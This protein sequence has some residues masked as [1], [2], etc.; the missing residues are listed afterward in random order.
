MHIHGII[1][2][3]AT[4]MLEGGCGPGA[5]QAKAARDYL[6]KNKMNTA[7]VLDSD[8]KVLWGSAAGKCK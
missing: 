7:I 6:K 8:S 5:P 4:P 3:V 2:P 1:P